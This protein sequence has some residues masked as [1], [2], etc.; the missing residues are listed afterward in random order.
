MSVWT[1]RTASL[2]SNRDL[3]YLLICSPAHPPDDPA[4]PLAASVKPEGLTFFDAGLPLPSTPI[5][6]TGGGT[7][8]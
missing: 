1:F 6:A 2:P 7:G 5:V 8:N 4:L 3:S